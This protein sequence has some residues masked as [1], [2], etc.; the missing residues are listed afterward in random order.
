MLNRWLA[1]GWWLVAGGGEKRR[2]EEK[3]RMGWD[4]TFLSA[5]MGWAVVMDE[6]EGRERRERERG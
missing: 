4:G 3:S 1:G 5:P 6:W 2:E